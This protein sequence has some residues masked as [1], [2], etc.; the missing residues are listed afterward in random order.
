M[1]PFKLEQVFALMPAKQI[2]SY[3]VHRH[4]KVSFL[5]ENIKIIKFGCKQIALNIIELQIMI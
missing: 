5:P 2:F 4:V 3:Y 1:A